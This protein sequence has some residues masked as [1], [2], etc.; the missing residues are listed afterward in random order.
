[1]S[2]ANTN[3]MNAQH[4]RIYQGAKGAYFV[5]RADG[6]KVYGVRA[7][8]R[9]VGANGISKLTPLFRSAHFY[10]WATFRLTDA[11]PVVTRMKPRRDPGVRC[12]RFVR[13]ALTKLPEPSDCPAERRFAAA[14]WLGDR[15]IFSSPMSA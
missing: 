7:A 4:R 12:S 15:F 1:M 6:K 2:A 13:P 10:F 3:F 14:L 5:K 11:A 8:F 9:K